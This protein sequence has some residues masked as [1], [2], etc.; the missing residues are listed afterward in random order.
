MIAHNC[1]RLLAFLA[2]F[3][4]VGSAAVLAGDRW[5]RTVDDIWGSGPF[6]GYV[7]AFQSGDIL[8]TEGVFAL[9]LQPV[10]SINYFVRSA[11]QT[12]IG[13]GGL[14]TFESLPAGR[15][16][17][18]LSEDA[19]VEALQQHPFLPIAVA[20]RGSEANAL[21]KKEISVEGGPITL[22]LSGVPTAS[23]MVEVL[24]L[25]D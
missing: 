16:A 24:R 1:Q 14:V 17:I 9:T 13:Y 4:V 8:P 20:R 2:A 21:R 6:V 25:S 23:I 12:G 18:V 22:Q 3:C 10:E 19:V 11:A 5:G 7:P 15:Y